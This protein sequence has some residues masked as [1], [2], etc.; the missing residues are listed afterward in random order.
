MELSNVADAL[1]GKHIKI[2]APASSGMLFHDYKRFYSI[3]LVGFCD[4]NYCF[5]LVD[6]GQFGSKNYSGVLANLSI[7]K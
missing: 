4:V 2:E 7:R 6:I 5:T 3:I 1:D